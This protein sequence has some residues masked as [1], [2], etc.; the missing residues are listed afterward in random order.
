MREMSHEKHKENH[1]HS[2]MVTDFKK[3][4]YISIIL[5]I[6]I[7]LL[8]PMI[9][10][11]LG[12]HEAVSF[13]GDLYILFAFSSAIFF[14]GGWPFLKGAFQ[15]L[16]KR[17]PG[18]MTLIGLAISVA[19]VYSSAIVFGL[20]GK[21]FFWELAS[22][23]DIML[24]G[25]WVE[26]RSVMG[27]GKA[28]EELAKLMPSEAHKIYEDGSVQDIP[29]SELL[30]ND[31]IL[32][33]PGEKVPADGVIKKG[34]SSLNESMLT[35]ESK[36]VEKSE[37]DRVIGGSINGDGSL[38]IVVDKTGRETFLS[39]VIDLVKDAQKSKSK[40]QDIAN[41]AAYWL[42]I[43]AILGGTLTLL[44]WYFL[45]DQTLS[46]ALERTV[47]VMVITCPHALGL[48]VPLV[49]A[50]STAIAAG[51]G[52]LIRNRVAF[53]AARN[54]NAIVFDKT[55]TLTKGEFGVTDIVVFSKQYSENEILELAAAVELHSEHPIAKGIVKAVE[56]PKNVE[57]FKSIPGKG[58]Q[59]IVDGKTIKT[60][61][62]G[63]L[64]ENKISVDNPSIN[65]LSEQGKTVIYVLVDEAVIGAIALADII[66][67]ESK[68]AI[69]KF[70]KL[71]IKCFMLTGDNKK[72]ANW[73]AKE[74][75]LDE[76]IAEVLPQEKS[77]KI[78]EVQKRGFTVA[79]T[80]DGVNDAPALAQADVGIAIGAGTD[81]AIETAD[82][83]LVKSSPLDALAII[84]LA[85]ATY[86]KMV[87]NLAW[88]TGYNAL[89]IPL[90]AGV[91][92]KYG[93]LLSPAVAAILMS[94]STVICA[95]NAKMLRIK[96]RRKI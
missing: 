34:K 1:S 59:G 24:L 29:L 32:V 3:R 9:H 67:E 12:I 43:V 77:Q 38:T 2:D 62:P 57:D 18:M 93:I 27:A 75:G 33:K 94:L 37:S 31:M 10:H 90:A 52:L 28:L 74:I 66:R 16:H 80:G 76:V 7:F 64:A 82:I 26:M 51:N 83:I 39:Q 21:V 48:A 88:A 23:I 95:V 40:T 54:I 61:S 96:S 13:P 44:T 85:K 42:T 70:K 86:N 65:Q 20:Q 8:S 22:L 91:L 35:G 4:F 79:M 56:K 71:G 84:E 25:H 73:V 45:S 68:Q 49:V 30:H 6:P 5:T 46:F 60:V 53:E 19:Y 69:A 87:Q 63:Y 15:E 81:V 89:A 55:G 50:V 14:Y 92:Y 78:K 36:P 17:T 11:L 72:V 58:A 41:Y 47:S